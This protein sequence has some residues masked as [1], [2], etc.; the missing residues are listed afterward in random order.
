MLMLLTA[1]SAAQATTNAT[2]TT[3]T[4]YKAYFSA[5]P[6]CTA[7]FQVADFGSTGRAVDMVAG[8]SFGSVTTVAAGTYECV[9]MKMSDQVTFV[10][11]AT[12]G[13]C[14]AGSSTTIDVCKDYGSGAPTTQDPET[15]TT[16]TCTGSISTNSTDTVFLYLS[17]SATTT[18]GAS[19]NNPFLPPTSS[20]FAATAFKMNGSVVFSSTT[21]G[22][23]VFNTTGKI[24]GVTTGSCDMNPPD[25]GFR[26]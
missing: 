9:I 18:S 24:D 12:D 17:T 2:S 16:S 7:P 8:G 20:D 1:A 25:F 23:F 15:G 22:T 10:P 21:T 13:A 6:L 11:E 19:T 4:V 26:L 3:V 5:S 14:T